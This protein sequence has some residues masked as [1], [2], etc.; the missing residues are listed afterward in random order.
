VPKV[1]A[2]YLEALERWDTGAVQ[3]FMS[4]GLVRGWW[5]VTLTAL[6]MLGAAIIAPAFTADYDIGEVLRHPWE[7]KH[8]VPIVIL[9]YSGWVFATL[10][11][12]ILLLARL[13][14]DTLNWT[15]RMLICFF[16]TT[17]PFTS[18]AGLFWMIIPPYVA[19]VGAF[20]FQ[21]NAMY[22]ILGSAILKVF[23]FQAVQKLQGASQLDEHSIAMTQKMDKVT[24]PIK[25]RAVL[26]GI[27]T[28]YADLIGKEDNS[29]WTSFGTSGALSSVKMW[30]QLVMGLMTLT[31]VIA[32]IHLII[33]ATQGMAPLLETV[34]PLCT[35]IITAVT[36]IW[37]AYEPFLFI[38]KGSSSALAPRWVEVGVL[39]LMFVGLLLVTSA[40]E[41][42]Y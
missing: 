21:L 14:P 12:T 13:S 41:A 9:L 28:G 23:E 4:Q 7:V 5:W 19:I 10:F 25:V 20:P 35:A 8:R 15:M 1:S 34:M 36:Y 17:Y 38:M 37:L 31:M 39:V 18:V 6:L 24:L 26:K 33:K 29:W 42:T 27:A 11:C 32:F 3:S 30:L 2:N 22:A 40:L 16:N